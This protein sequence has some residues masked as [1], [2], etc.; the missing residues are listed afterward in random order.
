MRIRLAMLLL[1]IL[2][3]GGIAAAFVQ[4]TAPSE[5]LK[6]ADEMTQVAV[7]IR[8]LEPKAPLARGVKSRDDIFKYLN[9]SVNEN[10]SQQELQE[11]GKL[12]HILGLIPASM[13]FKDYIL[14]LYTEQV[15]GFYDP[16]KR[17]F[18]IASWLPLDMQKPAMV[19]E[20]THAL[21]DQYFEIGKTLKQDRQLHNDDVALAHEALR[22]GDAVAVMLDYQLEPV[23]RTFSQL[24]DLAPVMGVVMSSMQSQFPV[25]NSAPPFLQETLFFPY[26]YGASFLQ[27]MWAKNPS[28]EFVNKAY[29]DLPASTEQIMHPEKYLESRDE[30]KSVNAEALVAKLGGGWKVSYKNVLG[31]FSMGLLLNVHLSEGRSKRAAAGWGGDQILLLENGSGKNAILVDTVW[32]TPEEA[33]EFFDAMQEWLQKRCPNASKSDE[34]PAGFSLTQDKEINSLHREGTG[35]RFIIGL[36]ASDAQLLRDSKF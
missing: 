17:T 36:P 5:L 25:F 30:P 31:E 3:L 21:Q 19:H 10:Y 4:E 2:A 13:D 32:D 7:R 1:A 29:S 6:T 14:K 33:N 26:R 23:K 11:E 35:V 28:W 12:L 15:A 16:E 8:G 24:P 20:L 27:K 34:T 18:F 22:E 9:D